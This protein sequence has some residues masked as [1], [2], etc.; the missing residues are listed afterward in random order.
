MSTRPVMHVVSVSSG[1]DSQKVLLKAL[2]RVPRE[3]IRAI[4]CDTENEHQHVYDH[5]TYLQQA[6][7][8][9]IVRLKADFTEQLLAKRLFIARDVRTR[10]EYKR[11]PKI[12]RNGQP[13][14]QKDRAGNVHMF[15]VY[16]DETG[17]LLR[18]EPRQVIGWDAGRKVKWSNKAKRRALSVMHPSGNAFLDLCMWKGRFPSRKAQFCTEELKRNIAVAYQIDLIDAG[19]NVVSWQGV[20][21]DESQNRRNAKAIERVGRGLWIYRPIVN[22]TAEQVI[23][24]SRERGVQLNPLYREGRSRV[25]CNPCINVNKAELRQIVARDPE[26]IDR[27]EKWEVIVGM[28]S[29]R[30][31]STF[32]TDAHSAKDRRRVYA[33]LNIRARVEWAKTTRG[34]RQYDLLADVEPATACSSAYGLCE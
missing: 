28:C 24:F 22:D 33:D 6:L 11:V 34:G 12:D 3:S 14:Y 25:G 5:L 15:A 30:G 29:K 31:F 7:D 9:P 21:R 10:R 23:H 8:I 19:Y 2:E 1:K 17:E 18:H 13:V 16:D 26:H 27:I 32:M 20:R 4:Y